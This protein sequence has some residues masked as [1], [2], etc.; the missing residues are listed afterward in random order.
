MKKK[1]AWIYASVFLISLVLFYGQAGFATFHNNGN[2]TVSDSITGL[3]WQQGDEQ[4]DS[5]RRSWDEAL[6]YCEG[7]NLAGYSDWRLPNV[8]E[9][10][11]IVDWSRF[12]PS[13]DPAFNCCSPNYDPYQFYLSSSTHTDGQAV[14]VVSFYSG[15][16]DFPLKGSEMVRCVRG[17][18][19]GSSPP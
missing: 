13:I 12:N 15:Q 9:L 4:N 11:S 3:M 19:G 1:A 14:W 5:G 10:E 6:D 2:G 8:R 18:P 17:G 7:L 16:V